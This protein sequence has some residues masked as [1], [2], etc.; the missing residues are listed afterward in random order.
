MSLLKNIQLIERIH[1]NILRKSTVNA[2][3]FAKRLKISESTLYRIL[4]E[5]RDLGAVVNFDSS[6]NS[7]VY[8]NE[9][10]FKILLNIRYPEK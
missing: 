7:Y 1:S 10:E 9:V 5:L 2:K 8:E 4:N 3:D 6:R